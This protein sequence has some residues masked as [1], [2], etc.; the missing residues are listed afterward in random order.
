M[1]KRALCWMLVLVMVVSLLPTFAAAEGERVLVDQNS[2]DMQ[3]GDLHMTKSLYKNSDHRKLGDRR[4]GES[5]SQ[6]GGAHGFRADPGP[7][8]L[9]V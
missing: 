7:V 8:R 9:Y 4:G 2:S 6:S 5:C 1:K 3:N